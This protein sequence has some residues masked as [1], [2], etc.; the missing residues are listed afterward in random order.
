MLIYTFIGQAIGL[1]VAL[2]AVAI[3][4]LYLFVVTGAHL[5]YRQFLLRR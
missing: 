4:M 5:E 3:V 1:E 2:Y